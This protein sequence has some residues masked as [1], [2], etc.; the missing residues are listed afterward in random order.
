LAGVWEGLGRFF[1]RNW[2]REDI[3][4]AAAKGRLE[5][6]RTHLDLGMEADVR[7]KAGNTPLILAAGSGNF[8]LVDLLLNRG[9][10]IDADNKQGFTPL[11]SA[12]QAGDVRMVYFLL[13]RGADPSRCRFTGESPLEFAAK[14]LRTHERLK[15]SG[16]EF[17]Q[18]GENLNLIVQL[19]QVHQPQAVRERS[20]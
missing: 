16:F 11:F 17:K 8:P 4:S 3:F 15:Q 10:N 6:V 5:T 18:R 7:D 12:V 19:L 20:S 1:K 9:A 2:L 13:E 14:L